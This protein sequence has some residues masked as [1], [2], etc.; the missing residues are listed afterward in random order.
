M[1]G[2]PYETQKQRIDLHSCVAHVKKGGGL[3]HSSMVSCTQR[4]V[5]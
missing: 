5:T 1:S 3:C 4:L 2:F